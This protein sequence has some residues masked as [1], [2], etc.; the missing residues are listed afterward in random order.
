MAYHSEVVGS[1]LRPT[2]LVEARKQFEADQLSAA[3]FKSIEDRAVNEAISLQEEVGLDVI[4][5]GELRRYAFYGHLVDALSGFD[6]YGGWAIPFRDESGEELVLRRPVVVEKLQWKRSMCAEEWVYLR[7][8]KSRPGKVTMI[9]AQQAAAY[10]DPEKSKAAYATRDAY[11]ADIVDFSRREVA[12]LVRLGCTYIQIDAPQYAALLDPQ[13]REGYRQR[14][15]DPDKIIDQCIAMDNAIIDGHPGVTFSMHI[16]RGNNQSKF[17]ASG[18]YEPISR[19]FSQTHFQRFL[20]EY[21]DAR[22]G[23]FDPLRHVPDDRFVV[24]GL[25]TTKKTRL[26]TADELRH[27]IREASQFVPLERLALSPQC[28]FASTMEG[29]HISFEDQHRKLELVAS[30]VCEIWGS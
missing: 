2:Y 13:M 12:E 26:E 21:D 29:N 17:Y 6:K 15:S 16:C 25:V 10:Y 11:L 5:D 30:V 23:G 19:I 24:L 28:G 22:S 27:R 3:D 20:L 9:S 8:R 14:G 4:T 7:S 18:D 1:L